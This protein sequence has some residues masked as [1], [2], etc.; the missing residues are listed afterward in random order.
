[1]SITPYIIKAYSLKAAA[2]E[3]ATKN[4]MESQ[5]R[6]LFELLARNRN[7]LFGKE[8]G[9]ARL[10]SIEDYQRHVPLNDYETLR[11]YIDRIM[12]GKPNVLTIDKTILLGVT[13]GTTGKPKHIPVT[14]FS[15]KK[16]KE[17]MD[18]WTYY[19]LKDHPKVLNGKIL[20]IVS[21]EKEGCTTTKIPFGAES[22]H[23]YKNMPEIVKNLYVLPYE[24]FEIKDYDA[25]YYCILRIAMEQNVSVVTSLNPSTI[26][27]LCQ[28][29]EKA[30][31]RIIDD[32]RHGTLNA[33]LNLRYDI[34]K[35]IESRLKPN[36]ARAEELARLSENRNG[37]LLPVNFWPN[38]DIILCWK[39][40]SVGIYISHF[41]KYFSSNI[42]IR[43]FGYLSS[44][45]R[46][47][48]PMSDDGCNGVLAVT[49]N[50]YEFIPREEINEKNKRFLLS[51]Q[52]ETGREYY[53][54]LTTPGNLYRYNIDDIIKV[55]G[56]FNSTP[57]IEF[58][59]KGSL[60]SSV[61]GEKIYELQINEAVNKA[62]ES[63][64]TSLQFFSAF[65]EW[66]IV[67]RYAFLMEFI[68]DIP[69]EKKQE[70]LENIERGLIRLNLEYETKRRSQRLEYPVL[71]VVPRGTFE[72]YRSRKIIEG[73]HDGQFKMPALTG[74]IDFHKNFE[75]E[76]EIKL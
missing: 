59:Q 10:R 46:V 53:I 24:V 12:R 22:G 58:K 37:E 36:P 48:I 67:P 17:V 69:K 7:T 2:F 62:A 74:N 35:K 43:D 11:P 56:F 16:K 9:F 13:S 25:K 63:I 15:R 5:R 73:S 71:K 66:G 28:R 45:A 40:G 23:A 64:G 21:P 30:K 70:L 68:S 3:K 41:K 51:Y 6:F 65:V 38:M 49:S 72:E 33:D 20:A 61:T 18:I 57:I 60:V 27:L 32:I 44:E 14:H 29:I 4:P 31:A 34:R 54:I 47:S 8:H 55:V 75:I 26:L 39:G 1:M 52:L 19:I 76:E 50:F 42:S